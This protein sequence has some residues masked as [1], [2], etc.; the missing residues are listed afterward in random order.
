MAV[1]HAL[2]IVLLFAAC[3]SPDKKVPPPTEV[4]TSGPLTGSGSAN[5][6]ER[7]NAG[8]KVA[9]VASVPSAVPPL[10]NPLPG[11][12]TTLAAIGDKT[13]RAAIGD[14]DGD[15]KNEI[16][17]C[18][19]DFMTV[20]DASGKKL[21]E[22]KVVDGIQKLVVV[23]LEGDGKAEIY[24]GWGQT[25]DH[26]DTKAHLSVVRF[27]QGVL[28]E[29]QI[30]QPATTRNESVSIVPMLDTKTIYFSYFDSKYMVSTVLLAHEGKSWTMK[31]ALP[32]I[33]M[34]SSFAR[35]DVDGDG[36][37]DLVVG[38][39]YG[40]D[41]GVDGDAFVQGMGD[42]KRTMIPSTRGLRSI[43]VVDGAVY[44]GDGWHQ[45]YGTL[46]RGLLSRSKIVGGA[47]VTNTIEDT[48]GQYAL[49]AIIPA[50]I[51]KKRVI[52]TLG[53]HYTRAFRLNGDKWEALTIAGLARDIAVGDLDG[54]PGDEILIVGDKTTE[55]VNLEGATW[56]PIP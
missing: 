26:M 34:A 35:G 10:P 9:E 4:P 31:P 40:D 30:L 43:A 11:K 12:R 6:A 22:L 20:L 46:G 52:V 49:E 37:P 45:N 2:G 47:F 14:L 23:D 3:Q 32:Q 24:A 48:S 41:K 13:W 25:R 44:M 1:R 27:N 55:I 19:S 53:S 56:S 29:E 7:P 17:V 50:M 21:G 42:A 54:K 15:H 36:K 28:R 5:G 51:E 38:R 39:V 18:D 33:R 8:Q 16:V